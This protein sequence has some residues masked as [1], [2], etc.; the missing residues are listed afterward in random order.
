MESSGLVKFHQKISAEAG[1]FTGSFNDFEA[2]GLSVAEVGDLDSNGVPDIA[3]GAVGDNDGGVEKGA[4]WMLMLESNG[5]VKFHQKISEEAGNFG[6]A[7]NPLGGFGY[8][9]AGMGDLNGDNIPELAVGV[10]HMAEEGSV[11]ILHINGM[12]E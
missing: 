9:V 2:F 6:G 3:V 1:N 10:P 8:S 4:V 11:W 5:M 7:L 12:N